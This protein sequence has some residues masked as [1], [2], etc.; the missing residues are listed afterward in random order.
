MPRI[1]ALTGLRWWAAFFVF[2]YHMLVFAPLPTAATAFLSKGFFGVTFFFVLSGFVL[3]WSASDRVSQST[4]YW[5]RFARVYPSHFVALLLAIPVFY[6][7][8]PNPEQSWIMP[9]SIGI[10]A[11]SFVLIQG[12]F[13]DSAILFS[14]NPAAWTLTCEAFFYALHPYISKV[15]NR[16][17]LRGSL[18][19][20]L[21][22]VMIAFGYR[23]AAV[24]W[25]GSI[26]AEVPLPIVRLMEFAIGMGL[27]WAFR[28]G[29]R[30]RVSVTLAIGALIGGLGAIT[31]VPIF[32]PGSRI[33]VFLTQFSNELV[34]VACALTVVALASRTL[35]GRRSFFASRVQVR[36][37]EWSYTFYLIHAT[38]VYTALAWLGPQSASWLN[39]IWFLLLLALA[40]ALAAA[41]HYAVEKPV[42]TRLRAWKD[43]R[44]GAK[45]AAINPSVSQRRRTHPAGMHDVHK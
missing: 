40:I 13:S 26:F 9:V 17:R 8:Q 16:L 12:W 2:G 39:L 24:T 7:L 14:G 37:G 45:S 22:T 30:P 34:T 10:L 44:S 28:C 3:T 6:S 20:V 1:D 32:F 41:L 21:A 42:E 18:I 33:A 4:F 35:A 25:P 23:G 5:R 11:L 36:L 27:A 43:A 15:L 31:S 29:W 38:I 19:F